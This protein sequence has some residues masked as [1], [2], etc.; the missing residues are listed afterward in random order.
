MQTIMMFFKTTLAPCVS[1]QNN[2]STFLGIFFNTSSHL[3][4]YLNL[5]GTKGLLLHMICSLYLLYQ[6]GYIIIIYTTL[7]RT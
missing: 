4:Q 7:L 2:Y 5:H 1:F 6:I 3:H